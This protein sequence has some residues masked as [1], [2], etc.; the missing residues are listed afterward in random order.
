ME[1]TES[2]KLCS[3]LI[4]LSNHSA[5]KP[6]QPN[7]GTNLTCLDNGINELLPWNQPIVISINSS[8]EIR[9]AGLLVIHELEEL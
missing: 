7:Q 6:N 5:N 9:D 3:K 1:S 2:I 4:A 8:E